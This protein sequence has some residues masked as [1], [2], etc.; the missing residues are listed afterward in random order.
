MRF[1][2]AF[3]SALFLLSS[4]SLFGLAAKGAQSQNRSASQARS[5]SQSRPASQSPPAGQA[6]QGG[7]PARPAVPAPAT[8]QK[9]TVVAAAAAPDRARTSADDQETVN[10]VGRVLDDDEE[11][12]LREEFFEYDANGDGMLDAYEVRITHPEI[13]NNEL[14]SFF[15]SVDANQDGLLTLSE[16]KNYV[17]S[18]M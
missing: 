14:F 3:V 2:V 9:E 1:A 7:Q 18:A 10:K 15:G 16:Y 17:A 8:A 13:A 6:S 4:L 11:D 12:Y 5:A